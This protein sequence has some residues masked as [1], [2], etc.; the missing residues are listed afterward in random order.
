MVGLLSF[1]KLPSVPK[2][3]CVCQLCQGA[4]LGNSTV[5]DNS[6]IIYTK[7]L[8]SIMKKQLTW[9]LEVVMSRQVKE[10]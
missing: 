4:K 2:K 6:R 9:S 7:A 3:N 10:P 1:N 8:D 5:V